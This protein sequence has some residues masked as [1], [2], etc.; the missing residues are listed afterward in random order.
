MTIPV[1]PTVR[2]SRIAVATRGLVRDARGAAAIEFAFVAPLYF[3]LVIGI[4]EL[5]LMTWFSGILSDGAA[6]AGQYLRDEAMN[7]TRQGS[8]PDPTKPWTPQGGTNCTGATIAGMRT[9]ICQAVAMGGVSCQAAKLK[10]AVYPADNP[11][12]RP[13]PN[14]ILVD[15]AVTDLK[16]SRA[17]VIALGYEWPFALPT[18]RLLLP[19]QG[20]RTQIQARTFVSTSERALR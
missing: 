14:P 1:P 20:D 10:L 17:Y 3:L 16:A 12:A 7:C 6:Q 4:A 13:I 18:T 15:E 11:I 8:A 5:A 9:A 19:R 2:P